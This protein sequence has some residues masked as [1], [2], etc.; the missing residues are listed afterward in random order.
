MYCIL[1]QN[2]LSYLALVCDQGRM[3]V[4]VA[5]KHTGALAKAII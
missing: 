2:L 1:S 5:Q 3:A 4:L